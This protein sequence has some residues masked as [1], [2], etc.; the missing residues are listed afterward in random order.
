MQRRIYLIIL[1]LP[2]LWVA[3]NSEKESKVHKNKIDKNFVYIKDKRFF[4]NDTV[5]FPMMIN[6][7]LLTYTYNG[8]PLIVDVNAKIPSKIHNVEDFQKKMFRTIDAHLKIIKDLGF[9][10][11]RLYGVTRFLRDNNKLYIN[12]ILDEKNTPLLRKLNEYFV[13]LDQVFELAKKN[14]LKVMFLFANDG[15]EIPDYDEFR[16]EVLK[17]YSNNNTIFS[18]DFFN[19]PLYFD[20]ILE[21]PK[22]N[23]YKVVQ[24]W[25]NMM[26]KYAPKQ[27]LTIGLSEPIEVFE[28]DPSILP[29]DFISFHTYDILRIPSEIFWYSRYAHKVWMIG[30][31]GLAADND[32]VSFEK[33]KKFMEKTYQYAINCGAAG[34]GIWQFQDVNWG[35]WRSGHKG[36][37]TFYGDTTINGVKIKGR[38]KPAAFII[39]KLKKI[40]PEE[41]C[42]MPNNYFNMRD[43]HKFLI[44]GYVF[45]A[46]SKKP[47][48]GAVIRGWTKDWKLGTN[49]Y[50]DSTGKFLLFS[51]WKF[52][53]IRISA[54]GYS[55]VK[56][57]RYNINYKESPY[58]KNKYVF[59]DS[60]SRMYK[61]YVNSKMYEFNKSDFYAY[62]YSGLL[63][64]VF[65][66]KIDFKNL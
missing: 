30:E 56:F 35:S 64:T 14:E 17:H 20:K 61:N 48:N 1:L 4:L 7:G 10:S 37:F 3:C 9:N 43:Y 40:K 34:F 18:Y 31:T 63:D 5:F 15:I 45:D 26:S 27:L 12:E 16:I 13:L 57:D 23:A 28:W 54:P 29:V 66:E 6:Y 53:H 49:T 38:L 36:L 51:D 41:P 50:T 22:K 19:E 25:K 8:T 46:N 47:I 42:Q 21:R 32:S 60:V 2:F 24:K 11:L 52:V 58:V 44:K 55:T 33:Q 39:K 65:L 59:L 62:K